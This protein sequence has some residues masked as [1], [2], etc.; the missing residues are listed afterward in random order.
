[1]ATTITN[2]EYM[3]KA[4]DGLNVSDNDIDLVLL[5]AEL[6]AD[7]AVDIAACDNA[8]YNR[9]SIVLKSMMQNITEAG[10]QI[11]WN[12]DAVKMYYNSLCNE[13]GKPNV[14]VGRPK[15][16]NRSNMW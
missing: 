13:I 10:Y 11:T 2:K 8:I 6:D 7:T 5:K 1:M 9:M 14:L 15:I 12:M 3:Q 16:R 4:L